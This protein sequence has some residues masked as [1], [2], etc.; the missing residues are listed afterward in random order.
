MAFISQAHVVANAWLR[1]GN[2]ATCSDC[3]E[4]MRGTFGETM[5]GTEVGL[6]RGDGGFYTDE[7]LSAFEELSLNYIIVA[8]ACA[9][10]RT[11]STA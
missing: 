9:T 7:I 1:P 11:R 2:T 3:V 6:V 5:A 4:F 8:H 10:S